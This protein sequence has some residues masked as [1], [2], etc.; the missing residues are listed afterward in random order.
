MISGQNP[1]LLKGLRVAMDYL[2]LFD[3][4]HHAHCYNNAGV[5]GIYGGLIYNVTKDT[6]CLPE[7][8]LMSRSEFDADY[9]TN[10]KEHYFLHDDEYLERCVERLEDFV[11]QQ[12]A[13][14]PDITEEQLAAAVKIHCDNERHSFHAKPYG[15]MRLVFFC[16]L[17]LDTNLGATILELYVAYATQL[18]HDRK[19]AKNDPS[20][21]LCKLH[22]VLDEIGL[23]P[24]AARLRN[25]LSNKDPQDFRLL[26]PHAIKLMQ[27]IGLLDAAVYVHDE[28]PAEWLE[29]N[30]ITAKLIMHRGISTI[31]SKFTMTHEEVGL[32]VEMGR[33]MLRLVDGHHLPRS[34]N[35]NYMCIGNPQ[36]LQLHAQRFAIGHLLVLGLQSL[37]CAQASYNSCLL[38]LIPPPKHRRPTQPQKPTKVPNP[39]SWRTNPRN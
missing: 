24:I 32:L 20:S 9:E 38:L 21:P 14:K 4:K 12:K 10:L 35:L 34:Y 23:E 27:N 18:S 5:S 29:R 8:K 17:H 33:C 2:P 22:K 31:H 25:R 19:F 39:L 1:H 36:L 26:G 13:A 6:L 16:V 11:K 3:L 28:R 7:A 30:T 15:F 37:G